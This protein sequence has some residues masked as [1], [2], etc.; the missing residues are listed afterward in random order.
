MMLT[1][2]NA[3]HSICLQR[4]EIGTH[5]EIHHLKKDYVY[6]H[7]VLKILQILQHIWIRVRSVE[8]IIFQTIRS[9]QQPIIWNKMIQIIKNQNQHNH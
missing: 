2:S 6:V 4:S 5:H 1:I 7:I 9:V 3:H 8:N